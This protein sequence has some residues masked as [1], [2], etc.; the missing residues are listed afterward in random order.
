MSVS[1]DLRIAQL[2]C[3]RI[4]HDLAGTVGAINNGMELLDEIGD[5][6]EARDLV[7]SS[8]R[9]VGR[10][11]SY[12]RVAFGLSPG[13]ANAVAEMRELATKLYNG[14]RVEIDW[15]EGAPGASVGD[16]A[17]KLILNMV[18]LGVEAL[19]RG[20]VIA[21]K[22]EPGGEQ[23]TEIFVTARGE[24]ASINAEIE[25][26]RIETESFDPDDASNVTARNVQGFLTGRLAHLAG[27]KLAIEAPA[28]DCVVLA[29]RIPPSA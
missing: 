13:T 22:L 5:D 19:P 4:C 23:D 26:A 20:G 9:E 7:T 8:A 3:S 11:L 29:A 12:F 14:T 25:A 28:E 17:T 6:P 15:P 27:A 24:R 2:L 16:N 18:M 21:V 1:V 10:R